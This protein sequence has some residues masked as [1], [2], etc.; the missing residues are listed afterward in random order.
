MTTTLLSGDKGYRNEIPLDKKKSRYDLGIEENGI[1]SVSVKLT[2]D[3]DS[4]KQSSDNRETKELSKKEIEV[5]VKYNFTFTEA[6][7]RSVD[8]DSKAVT[9]GFN[10]TNASIYKVAKVTINGVEYD[11]V[12]DGDVY[13]VKLNLDGTDRTVLNIT[14]AELEDHKKFKVDDVSLVVFKRAPS[15]TV[16]A[17]TGEDVV[18]VS[19]IIADQENI[20]ENVRAILKTADGEVKGT[21]ALKEIEGTVA[22]EVQAGAYLVEI[23]ADYDAVDGKMHKNELLVSDD[24]IMPIDI[25]GISGKVS[26]SYVNKG[27]TV[28]VIYTVEDNTYEDV[29]AFTVSGKDYTA[30]GLGEGKY[31]ISYKAGN[32]AGV[33]KLELTAVKYA[34][35][36]V[37]VEYGSAIE[38]LKD[39]PTVTGF[40]YDGS[41]KS[42]VAFTLNDPDNA[43]ISG[44]IIATSSNGEKT[45]IAVEK[46]K[47]SYDLGLKENGTYSISVNVTYDLDENKDD[48]TNQ[49]TEALYSGEIQVIVDY[50]FKFENAQV[51]SVDNKNMTVQIGFESSNA[52]IYPLTKL[53]VNGAEYDAVKTGDTSY[54]VSVQLQ[55][56]E[57]TEL[58]IT[59]AELEDH[60]KFDVSS[61]LVVFKTAPA[62]TLNIAFG[63]DKIDV[64]YVVIDNEGIAEN[65]KLV[66]CDV[67]GEEI[68]ARDI[69]ARS[70]EGSLE[71]AMTQSTA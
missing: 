22:F 45:E 25:D 30:E 33:E 50:K 66:L 10:S 61:T 71:F 37:A 63:E 39:A 14:Q 56:R 1:Y 11:A 32:T 31:K 64:G 42:T 38:V 68:A 12:A 65:I 40:D 62:A 23:V 20:A 19:Y 9:I 58:N 15:A 35:E 36:T 34:S 41:E 8:Y 27:E 3:L 4:D 47:N 53:T 49:K 48:K 67:Y 59:G 21:E 70:L 55:S 17:I 52:S 13:T 60:K 51:K 46:N 57:K 7:V 44:A 5:I 2:Y 43:F 26:K 24:V 16:N 54:T 28:E 29:R 6:A 69:K 18:N